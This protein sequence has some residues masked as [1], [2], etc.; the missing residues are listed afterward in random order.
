MSTIAPAPATTRLQRIKQL[1]PGDAAT[2]LS[3]FVALLIGS[4]SR[5]VFG[6][7]GG[8]GTPA[9]I[10]GMTAAIW[11]AANGLARAR[12]TPKVPQR[13]RRA[14]LVFSGAILASY[15]AATV[16]PIE[17]DELASADRGLLL[18]LAWWGIVLVAMDGI[19][20]RARLD[21]VIRR[22]VFAG[23]AV[24]TLGI[25]QFE[26]GIAFTNFLRLPGLTENGG[27]ADIGNRDGFLR[28]SGTAVHPIEFGVALNI[29][30]PL[31]I[32]YAMNDRGLR[33]PL[34]RW[35]PVVALAFCISVSVS[36]SAILCVVVALA[37]LLPTWSRDVRRKAYV[38]IGA[39]MAIVYLTVPGMLGTILG[40]FTGISNDSSA[41]SRTDSYGIALDFIHRSPFFGRGFSTFF[42]EYHI[43]D[44][45]YLGSVIEIGIVGLVALLYL[46]WS[47]LSTARQ[48][49]RDSSDPATRSLAQALAASLASGAS[50]FA[51]FDAFSFPM[52]P[53]LM[54]LV[55]GLIAALYRLNRTAPR[56]TTAP[57]VSARPGPGPRRPAPAAPR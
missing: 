33:R 38:A 40:L 14:L 8:A 34:R 54:F 24:A 44:N 37:M 51:L 10:L 42:P 26:T 48:V 7:L 25:V 18:L 41:Q 4:P 50:S 53:G 32:H 28:P 17:A 20:T 39:L 30:L 29:F 43:L 22:L 3:F 56:P 9:Q 11:W 49:R 21:T 27:L 13:I 55:L 6:P 2:L 5:Y 12:R 35:Y 19:P 15:V 46:W 45:Q 23:G 16:R 1:T 52:V 57:A 47:G 36:R 31:A